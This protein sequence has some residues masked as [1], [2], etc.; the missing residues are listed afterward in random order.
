MSRRAE[1][2][3]PRRAPAHPVVR[4]DGPGSSPVIRSALYPMIPAHSSGAACMFVEP[5]GQAVGEF[6]VD[7]T[8][9]ANPP[10]TVQPVNWA[11]SHRFSLRSGRTCTRRTLR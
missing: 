2:V 9:S 1:P 3:M 10:S 7:T 5:F 8:R 11:L 4:V 6:G